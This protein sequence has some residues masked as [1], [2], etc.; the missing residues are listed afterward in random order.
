MSEVGDG[1]MVAAVDDVVSQVFTPPTPPPIAHPPA[2]RYIHLR[3]SPV[4][5]RP[6]DDRNSIAQHNTHVTGIPDRL[7]KQSIDALVDEVRA[8][9]TVQF[10]GDPV[11]INERYPQT[12]VCWAD[13]ATQEG[14]FL[15]IILAVLRAIL[16]TFMNNTTIINDAATFNTRFEAVFDK[17]DNRLE[18]RGDFLGVAP[19]RKSGSKRGGRINNLKNLRYMLVA[20]R[21]PGI[22]LFAENMSV[23]HGIPVCIFCWT[24]LE[25]ILYICHW[26]RGRIM[27]L[28][29]NQAHGTVYVSERDITD[30]MEWRDFNNDIGNSKLSYPFFKRAASGEWLFVYSARRASSWVPKRT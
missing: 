19:P 21:T 4:V 8:D 3:P 26:R 13:Y 27:T 12:R 9:G 17:P 18:N 2:P 22:R 25:D 20:G 10:P 29:Q 6:I 7:R 5:I 15:L 11:T 30:Y 28:T 1:E 24:K 14:W 16:I 23:N